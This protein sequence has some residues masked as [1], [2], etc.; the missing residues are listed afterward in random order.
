MK[1][2]WMLPLTAVAGGAVSF[3]L[4]L[5]QMRTG[6]EPA[7][8]LPIPGSAAGTALAV[9]L[10]AL[11]ALLLLL[12][13][14][15]PNETE[16]G[17]AFPADFAS[18]DTKL[19]AL[20]VTGVFLMA[21]SGLADIYEGLGL[22]SLLT[23]MAAAA[24]GG[25]GEPAMLPAGTTGF[26]GRTQLLMG[27]LSI[28]SA[29]GLFFSLLACRPKEG[30]A[31]KPFNGNLLLIAPVA[32]VVRLVLTYR[33]DSVNPALAAYYV[34]LLA[35]VFLTLGFYR[36]SSFAFR[37]GRTRRFALYAGA[38][39]VLSAAALADGAPYLSSILLYAGG[40]LALLGFLLL[41]LAARPGD[42]S[43]IIA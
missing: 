25:Y 4:R 43:A 27:V 21:L 32:L 24:A 15:L 6:F 17:P 22:G 33:A 3:V 42:D 5:V 18:G 26:S 37:S 38:A 14:R 13:R 19:L 7:T 9:L 36:L 8:G 16:Q 11:A 12:A 30:A 20:P 34:E 1:K 28:L 41:R 2:Q 39:V 35:L 31:P 23:Q 29:A 10:A 40:A